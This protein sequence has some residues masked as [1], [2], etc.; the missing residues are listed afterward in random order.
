[1]K[2]FISVIDNATASATADEMAAIHKFNDRLKDDGRWI[3]AAGLSSPSDATV[4]DN[5]AEA[6]IVTDG[7]FVETKEWVSG[8]W[9][10]DAPD[11]DTAVALAT[12]GSKACNRRV[13]VRSFLGD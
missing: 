2:F 10:I 12:E 13:E 7:P 11:R 5:R 4:I 9:I 8:F 6:A 1:M 3:F